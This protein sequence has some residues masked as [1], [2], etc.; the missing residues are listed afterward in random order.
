[1]TNHQHNLHLPLP[2]ALHHQLREE[3]VRSGLPATALVREALGDWLARRRR[4]RLRVEIEAYALAHAG[5]QVDLDPVLA[6]EAL[7]V[8]TEEPWPEDDQAP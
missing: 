5:S 8:L 4:E 2:D 3:S 7:A 1:M 6:A